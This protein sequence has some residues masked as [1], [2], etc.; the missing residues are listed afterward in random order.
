MKGGILVKTLVLSI[1]PFQRSRLREEHIKGYVV[2]ILLRS[3]P[4]GSDTFVLCAYSPHSRLDNRKG[5]VGLV[6]HDLLLNFD[7]VST[8]IWN[9]GIAKVVRSEHADYKAGDYVYNW[10]VRAYRS[11]TVCLLTPVAILFSLV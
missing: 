10:E 6:L 7:L 11:T 2:C 3:L 5:S 8:R 9:I 4:N 1:D